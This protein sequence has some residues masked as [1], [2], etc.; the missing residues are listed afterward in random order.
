[1][2]IIMGIL[3]TGAIIMLITITTVITAI[4]IITEDT[5][6]RKA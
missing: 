4:I 5:P 6:K 3:I 1:M 2:V